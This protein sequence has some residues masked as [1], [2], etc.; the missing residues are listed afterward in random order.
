M[1]WRGFTFQFPLG[2]HGEKPGIADA[3]ERKDTWT[4]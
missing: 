3:L 4:K 2:E 1:D